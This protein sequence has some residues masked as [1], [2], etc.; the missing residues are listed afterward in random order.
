MK[1]KNVRAKKLSKEVSKNF[2]SI[3]KKIIQN[4]FNNELKRFDKDIL[5]LDREIDNDVEYVERWIIERRKF[6][7]KLGWVALLVLVLF[8]ISELFLTVRVGA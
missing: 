3:N 5:K 6:F 8:I 2:K 4:D 7:I 1:K